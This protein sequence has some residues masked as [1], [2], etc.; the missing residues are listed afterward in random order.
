[1]YKQSPLGG[2]QTDS[3][4]YPVDI[5]LREKQ[6]SQPMQVESTGCCKTLKREELE[7]TVLLRKNCT[8]QSN[9]TMQWRL[10]PAAAYLESDDCLAVAAVYCTLTVLV[11]W[12]YRIPF[13]SECNK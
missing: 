8:L 2:R 7:K 9:K 12:N 1:M 10:M 5:M 3:G 13:E 6:C 11:I 4:S